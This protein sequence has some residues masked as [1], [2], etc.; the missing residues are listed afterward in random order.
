MSALFKSIV[1][2]LIIQKRTW[3]N[4]KL[5]SG[6]CHKHH[7]WEVIVGSINNLVASSNKPLYELLLTQIDVIVWRYLAM[8]CQY[9]TWVPTIKV[10]F[11]ASYYMYIFANSS[12]LLGTTQV[13]TTGSSRDTKGVAC[14]FYKIQLGIETLIQSDFYFYNVNFKYRH[15]KPWDQDL[16][17]YS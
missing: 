15:C 7:W 12:K 14:T 11:G 1:Y 9:L 16:I 5:L 2:K 17:W 8:I 3:G 6:K 4:V 13:T 10:A